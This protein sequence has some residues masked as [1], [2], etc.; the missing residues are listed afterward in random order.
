LLDFLRWMR[1]PYLP[2]NP[3][4]ADLDRL[5]RDNRYLT[6]ARLERGLVLSLD[7]VGG[8]NW[9]PRWLRQGLDD[10][11]VPAAIVIYKW[12]VGPLGLWLTDLVVYRRNRQK[13]AAL[14]RKIAEY[15]ERMPGR[16]VTLIGHSGGGAMAAFTLESLP[17]GVQVDRA[18][19]LAPALSPRY[20]LAP[21]LRGVRDTAYA[22]HSWIDFG[23]MGLGTLVCGTMDRRHSPSAGL[24]GF[25]LPRD[26]SDDDRRQYAKLRQIGWRPGLIRDGNLGDHSGCTNIPFSRRVLAPIVL[27]RT[28]PGEQMVTLTSPPW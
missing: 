15:R 24:V 13:A 6:R 26:L 25:R 2:D 27:G 5:P 9:L 14:A 17:A 7:G 20:N 28:D 1:R 18:L 21:A 19:L 11:G 4:P 22:T 12:S 3:L 8:Y 10:G 23:L 16:P